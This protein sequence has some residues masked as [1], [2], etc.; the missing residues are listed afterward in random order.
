[1]LTKNWEDKLAKHMARE[2][3]ALGLSNSVRYARAVINLVR[4]F[5]L[6]CLINPLL[7]I[8]ELKQRLRLLFA[9]ANK[10]ESE[11][12]QNSLYKGDS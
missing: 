6:E 11:P 7:E 2:L 9:G 3:K 4:G 12:T 10:E 1:M 5:E 8:D